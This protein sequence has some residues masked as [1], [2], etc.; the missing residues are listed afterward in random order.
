VELYL[1][2]PICLHGVVLHDLNT[3][4]NL[5]SLVNY[6][7]VSGSLNQTLHAR[8][9]HVCYMSWPSHLLQ[10]INLLKYGEK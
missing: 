10:S 6:V 2:S 3:G 1:H 9:L 7:C 8:L 4:T 5:L